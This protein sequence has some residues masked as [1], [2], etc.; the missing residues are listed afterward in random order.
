VSDMI[1]IRE[2]NSSCSSSPCEVRQHVPQ[3]IYQGFKTH[4]KVSCCTV[5]LCQICIIQSS[6]M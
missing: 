4:R 2:W 6:S 3:R 1:I 5:P